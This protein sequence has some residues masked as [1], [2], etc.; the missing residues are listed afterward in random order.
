VDRA[1]SFVRTRAPAWTAFEKELAGVRAAGSVPADRIV[2]FARAYR[3]AAADLSAARAMG[4]GAEVSLRLNRLVSEAH[5]AVYRRRARPSTERRRGAAAR[6]LV[7]LPR[8]FAD[9]PGT[10]LLGLAF[11]LGSALLAG[12]YVAGDERRVHEVFP[13]LENVIHPGDGKPG[14][15]LNVMPATL[16]S[17]YIVNNS[18]VAMNFLAHGILLGL[19]TTWFLLVNGSVLGALAAHFAHQGAL[20]RFW[21]QILPH[22]VTEM[23]AMMTGAQAG[24]LLAK[25]FWRPGEYSRVDALALRGREAGVLAL[26]TVCLMVWSGFVE[27][28]LTRS[29]ADDGV[30]NLFAAVAAVGVAA[31][32]ALALRAKREPEEGDG[33]RGGART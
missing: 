11:F 29:T 27:S 18:F 31:W 8:A 4:C 2:A 33:V 3:D 30:R 12:L 13:T 6:M 25:A 32:F 26:A 21:P 9:H 10:A 14:E 7:A 1:E 17:F 15:K 20:H 19:G 23:L 22:G 16:T 24:F 28:Y 5:G